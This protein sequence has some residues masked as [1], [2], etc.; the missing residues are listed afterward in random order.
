LRYS[1]E[2]TP[3]QVESFPG[4]ARAFGAHG[5]LTRDKLNQVAYSS[6]RL[7]FFVCYLNAE[8]F[9]CR[10]HQ[11]N[12]IKSHRLLSTGKSLVRSS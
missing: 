9:F 3:E 6:D 7:G 8:A 5:Q 11:L 1:H 12:T 4:E 10:H 2:G